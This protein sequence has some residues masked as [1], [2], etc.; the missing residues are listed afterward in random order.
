L[1]ARSFMRVPID[2]CTFGAAVDDDD[3]G[4]P[5]APAVTVSTGITVGDIADAPATPPVVAT[6]PAAAV[7]P[8]AAAASVADLWWPGV[9]FAARS[10]T[11]A[12]KDLCGLA[13]PAGLVDDADELEPLVEDGDAVDALTADEEVDPTP[14]VADDVASADTARGAS[15]ENSGCGLACGAAAFVLECFLPFAGVGDGALG[16]ASAD[17][18]AAECIG[19]DSF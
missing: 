5:K 2:L 13:P 9:T 6:P 15:T 19:A 7:P 14:P 10:L 12:L 16:T 4:W 3:A 18:S 1:A 11:R 8:P 17:A